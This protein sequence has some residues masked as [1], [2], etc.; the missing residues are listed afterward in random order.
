MQ[1]FVFEAQ[2]LRVL[3]IRKGR[4]SEEDKYMEFRPKGLAFFRP[5]VTLFAR[6]I[7]PDMLLVCI[8]I[9]D[10][11]SSSANVKFIS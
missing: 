1:V 10:P 3:N 11:E 9:I 8:M 2:A 7:S 5:L 4:S 6:C